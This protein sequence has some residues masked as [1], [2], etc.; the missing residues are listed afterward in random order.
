MS[1]FIIKS[2]GLCETCSKLGRKQNNEPNRVI[3]PRELCKTCV[4]R[5]KTSYVEFV[6]E[7]RKYYAGRS[8]SVAKECDSEQGSDLASSWPDPMETHD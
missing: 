2:E 5:L 7:P 4:R 3:N 1:E 8:P 6:K